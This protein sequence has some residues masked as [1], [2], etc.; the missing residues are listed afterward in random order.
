MQHVWY[1]SLAILCSPNED[2]GRHNKRS[3]VSPH[4]G[5][6]FQGREYMIWATTRWKVLRKT[7]QKVCSTVQ[8]LRLGSINSHTHAF[9]IGGFHRES[10]TFWSP[11]STCNYKLWNM[12]CCKEVDTGWFEWFVAQ[13]EYSRILPESSFGEH[14]W[15]ANSRTFSPRSKVAW[16]DQYSR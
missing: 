2:F 10:R 9:V 8:N 3:V 11:S 12:R 13:I 6:T 14:G 1:F 15:R 7:L 16:I 4:A 5:S